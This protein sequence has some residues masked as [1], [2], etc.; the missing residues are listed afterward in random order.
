MS[1]TNI[2]DLFGDSHS[3]RQEASKD[4]DSDAPVAPQPSLHSSKEIFERLN[5]YFKGS[6]SILQPHSRASLFQM[7]CTPSLPRRSTSEAV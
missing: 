2:V 4:Q 5:P 6:W 7:I 3:V 1:K